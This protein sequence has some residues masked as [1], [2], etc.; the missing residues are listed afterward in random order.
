MY[1]DR[2]T[3]DYAHHATSREQYASLA[4]LYVFA[5]FC[6]ILCL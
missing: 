3:L 2:L 6:D 1:K 4:R 5:S